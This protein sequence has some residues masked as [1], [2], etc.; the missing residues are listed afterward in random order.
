MGAVSS[1][2][3]RS[4]APFARRADHRARRRPRPA[5][6]T[7]VEAAEAPLAIDEL[8]LVALLG[9]FAEGET[10]VRGAEELRL[11][12]SDRIAT[13][14][15]G[16]R[17]LGADI[18][19][20]RTASSC[21]AT[22]AV[23]RRHHRRQRRPPHGD[24][25]RGGRARLRARAWR[26]SGWTPPPCRIPA[27]SKTSARS[28]SLPADVDVEG[29]SSS[30]CWRPS[31]CSS[32]WSATRRWRSGPPT[33][34]AHAVRGRPLLGRRRPRHARARHLA[35]A[36]PRRVRLL[37]RLD[38][39][40][41]RAW[42]VPPAWARPSSGAWP[43]ATRAGDRGALAAHAH[44]PR[45]ARPDDLEAGRMSL[46]AAIRPDDWNMPLFVHVLGAMVLV[47]SLVLVVI[48]LAGRDLR[49]GFRALLVRGCPGWI[50]M[51]GAPSGSPP[52]SGVDDLDP[53]PSLGRPG[54]RPLGARPPPVPH[55]DHLRWPPPRRSP[56]PRPPDRAGPRGHA[57]WPPS[58]RSGRCARSR[59]SLRAMVVAIDGPAGAGRARSRAPPRTRSVLRTSTP[60]RCTGRSA[61]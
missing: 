13:V 21:A 45:P 42:F 49:L 55:R 54:L 61:S 24:A 25:R 9:R 47:G 11:K 50:M 40:R 44:G 28:C 26:W 22:A 37:R 52:R 35:R 14:V 36:S 32:R 19:A 48:S 38:P 8:P 2:T 30:I 12:E 27:S 4:R 39:R 17:G 60:A 3:S 5:P 15:D 58:W 59:R 10:V 1:A 34:R 53:T 31:C 20:T 51:R 46:L 6:G 7:V 56:P 57:R 29:C 43:R 41:D 18:E 23:A 16:L 33:G